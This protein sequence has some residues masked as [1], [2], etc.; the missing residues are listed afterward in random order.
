[1]AGRGRDQLGAGDAR[2]QR[3]LVV[4]HGRRAWLR[5]PGRGSR[6]IPLS[7]ASLVASRPVPVPLDVSLVL[8]VPMPAP[9]LSS[10]CCALQWV[11]GWPQAHRRAQPCAHASARTCMRGPVHA[12]RPTHMRA[13]P[14]ASPRQPRSPGD[15]PTPGW[16]AGPSAAGTVSANVPPPRPAPLPLTFAQ[17]PLEVAVGR[18]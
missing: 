1:M 13:K 16:E 15:F 18:V 8:C 17:T 11:P 9:G 6:T 10:R 4:P 2:V 12:C 7:R 3:A 14:Q 5:H